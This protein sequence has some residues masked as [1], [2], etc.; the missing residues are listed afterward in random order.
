MSHLNYAYKTDF[1]RLYRSRYRLKTLYLILYY[2]P[3]SGKVPMIAV[4][5]NKKRR[6]VNTLNLLTLATNHQSRR[7]S[8]LAGQTR[9]VWSNQ[10]QTTNSFRDVGQEKM[11]VFWPAGR[12]FQPEEATSYPARSTR[13]HQI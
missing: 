6:Q 9:F 1:L 2:H 8:G 13:G 12:L 5:K 4:T 7:L 10:W 11:N 3:A